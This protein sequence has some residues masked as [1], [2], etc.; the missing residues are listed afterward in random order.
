[1]QKSVFFFEYLILVPVFFIYPW[2][3]RSRVRVFFVCILG[4]AHNYLAFVFKSNLWKCFR[5]RV[6]FFALRVH[7]A[8]FIF[9]SRGRICF[10]RVSGSSRSFWQ[11]QDIYP[12]TFGTDTISCYPVRLRAPYCNRNLSNFGSIFSR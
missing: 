8:V 10:F 2:R 6:L 9:L 7:A 4:I 3:N 1:M 12:T 5:F 11:C